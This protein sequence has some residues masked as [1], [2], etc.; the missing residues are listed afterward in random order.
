M[1]SLNKLYDDQI[2]KVFAL[3][4]KLDGTKKKSERNTLK[5]EIQK[6]QA[7]A[8]N[9]DGVR[10]IAYQSAIDMIQQQETDLIQR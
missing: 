10:N 4:E 8:I 2:D 9:L 7:H 3:F 5:I 6:A 1:K